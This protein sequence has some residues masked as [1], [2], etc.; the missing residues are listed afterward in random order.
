MK[1]F[2]D[3]KYKITYDTF[4]ESYFVYIKKWYY[5][6]YVQIGQILGYGTESEAY[7]KLNNY[8]KKTFKKESIIRSGIIVKN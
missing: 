3:L 6:C 1:N 7:K 2:F 5:P 4:L 8:A